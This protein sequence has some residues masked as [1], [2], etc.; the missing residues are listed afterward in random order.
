MFSDKRSFSDTRAIVYALAM[1]LALT[2]F[3]FGYATL[4]LGLFM[5]VAMSSIWRVSSSGEDVPLALAL[6]V[7][8]IG[9]ALLAWGLLL[10]QQHGVALREIH[11]VPALGRFARSLEIRSLSMLVAGAF[12]VLAKVFGNSTADGN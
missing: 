4:P 11:R 1:L 9:L 6:L 8:M 12:L 5:G 3:K 2:G 7:I 10:A